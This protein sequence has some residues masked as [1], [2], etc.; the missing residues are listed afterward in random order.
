MQLNIGF[1]HSLREATKQPPC[2]CV[3]EGIGPIG[4]ESD[5]DKWSDDE[6][7]SLIVV[8]DLSDETFAHEA[9]GDE[10]RS[11]VVHFL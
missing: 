2:H 10:S 5:D 1:V 3:F 11:V 6:M 8:T 7:L 9:A 4:V